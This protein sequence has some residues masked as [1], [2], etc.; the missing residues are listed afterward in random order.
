MKDDCLP[1]DLQIQ[2]QHW[3]QV[4]SS[5]AKVFHILDSPLP[6]TP[7]DVGSILPAVSNYTSSTTLCL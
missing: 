2:Y 7:T 6:P 3:I 4:L 5:W 1:T